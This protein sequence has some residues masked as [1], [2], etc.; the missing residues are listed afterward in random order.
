MKIVC[1][2]GQH[3]SVSS[4]ACVPICSNLQQWNGNVC[5]CRVGYEKINGNCLPKCQ[6]NQY[7]S[8]NDCLCI[9]GYVKN[10][11]GVCEKVIQCPPGQKL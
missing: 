4:N 5:V 2:F 8:N 10:S 1:P 3:Y 6:I 9:P 11:S 7:R